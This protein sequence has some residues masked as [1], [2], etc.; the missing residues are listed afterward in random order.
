MIFLYIV[1]KFLFFYYPWWTISLANFEAR[2]YLSFL[3]VWERVIPYD[4]RK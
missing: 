3:L 2:H 4:L 1:E